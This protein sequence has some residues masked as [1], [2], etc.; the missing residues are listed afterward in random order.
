MTNQKS[1]NEARLVLDS[2]LNVTAANRAFY[3]LFKLAPEECIG[4]KVY[5]LGGK[6]WDSKLR[7]M[8]EAARDEGSRSDHFE[9]LHDDAVPGHGVL[10]LTAKTLPTQ[11][12]SD[13]SILLLIEDLSAS[14][15]PEDS[16]ADA[17]AELRE[18]AELAG[19]SAHELN[20]MLTVVRM[21][22]ELLQPELARK[23]LSLLE[24]Q[25]IIDAAV[26]AEALA[27][28]LLVS[29][30]RAFPQPTGMD[31]K[32]P[33]FAAPAFDTGPEGPREQPR[34][35]DVV[36]SQTI[37]LVDDE[38]ALRKLTQRIL[39]EAG[40]RVLE[41]SDGAEALRVAAGEV[42]EIDLVLTDVEMPTLGGRGLVAELSE[43]SPQIKVLFM[44]GYTDN[45]I[46]RRGIRTTKTHFLQ[47]PFTP[48]GLR[49]AVQSALTEPIE[50]AS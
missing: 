42:G 18:F 48:S 46:L 38:K 30:R 16:L 41:A 19:R 12:S 34:R 32:T 45:E 27:R 25:D 5:E 44:S 49:I 40:Y 37:L 24:A 2:D 39:V 26:R 8:L 1:P 29:S 11:G 28:Q 6:A 35:D 14:R 23:G 20:N 15:S 4:T 13:Q 17:T 10:W 3:E 50:I 36:G 7:A 33:V 9:L 43:L 22:A 47:K 21:N 31:G